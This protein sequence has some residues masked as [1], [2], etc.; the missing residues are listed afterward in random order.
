MKLGDIPFNGLY[1]VYAKGNDG[2]YHRLFTGISPED[3]PTEH[4][5]DEVTMVFPYCDSIIVHVKEA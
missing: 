1:H 5:K 2:E 4:A 3:I